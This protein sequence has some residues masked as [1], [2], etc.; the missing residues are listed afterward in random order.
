MFLHVLRRV[1]VV[2]HEMMIHHHYHHHHAQSIKKHRILRVLL[3][4]ARVRR[5]QM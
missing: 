5:L 1:V 4:S 2:H 3:A